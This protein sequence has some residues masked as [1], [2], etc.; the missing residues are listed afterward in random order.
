MLLAEGRSFAALKVEEIAQRAGLGRTNFYF[1]FSDKQALLKRLA[2]EAAD[3]LYVEADRWWH[4]AGD[5]AEELAR[6]IEP[7][8]T[9]W[10]R[11]RA[12]LGAVVQTAAVDD[13]IRELWWS[14]VTRFVDATRIRMEH[15]QDAGRAM[16]LAPQ[17]TAFCLVW[18]TERACFQ[19]VQS[20][21][22][23]PDQLAR[24]LTDIW[25]R[26]VYGQRPG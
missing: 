13:E 2:R 1:Y 18:M 5:G 22:T 23:A 15:E 10:I 6:I 4:G 14:I 21:G 17:E 8:V 7:I 26:S 12:V 3:E 24:S 11:H 19:H 9:L 25:L 16:D 20:G